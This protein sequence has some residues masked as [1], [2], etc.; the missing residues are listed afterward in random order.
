MS[1]ARRDDFLGEA[2][3]LGDRLAVLLVHR[4]QAFSRAQQVAATLLFAELFSNWGRGT[5]NNVFTIL[6][7]AYTTGVGIS[8]LPGG[9][10]DFE[11]HALNLRVHFRAGAAAARDDRGSAG[12]AEVRRR[13]LPAVS[14]PGENGGLV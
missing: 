1:P 4:G 14:R 2:G 13:K 6:S 8:L 11:R 3:L 7:P 9:I 10:Q 5:T 12:K